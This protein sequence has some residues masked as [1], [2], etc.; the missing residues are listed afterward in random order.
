M[1]RKFSKLLALT[2]LPL[3][4]IGALLFVR[5]HLVSTILE[6]YTTRAC[7]KFLGGNCTIGSKTKDS[8]HLYFQDVHVQN[9]AGDSVFLKKVDVTWEYHATPPF[10]TFGIEMTDL[11]GDPSVMP[12]YGVWNL[13]K[14]A[15][16]RWGIRL[17]RWELHEA[18]LLLPQD[19]EIIAEGIASSD[20]GQFNAH[21][22]GYS[23]K[24]GTVNCT[25]LPDG[26]WHIELE[27]FPV[28]TLGRLLAQWT[29]VPED[30]LKIPASGNVTSSVVFNGRQIM[31]RS[32]LEQINYDSPSLKIPLAEIDFT[33]QTKEK[34]WKAAITAK[35]IEVDRQSL[36]PLK[37]S[38]TGQKYAWNLQASLGNT[39]VAIDLDG[40]LG[41]TKSLK[42]TIKAENYPL[43]NAW[44]SQK[45]LPG[46]V[47]EGTTDLFGEIDS[48]GVFVQFRPQSLSFNASKLPALVLSQGLPDSIIAKLWVDFSSGQKRGWI[49][50]LQ[51][52]LLFGG[53]PEGS[54][55]MDMEIL[56]NALSIR[57][58]RAGGPHLTLQGEV[59]G[60]ILPDK[61]TV[62]VFDGQNSRLNNIKINRLQAY[63]DQ[64]KT[65]TE[66]YFEGVADRFDLKEL[67]PFG[68]DVQLLPMMT[69]KAFVEGSYRQPGQI[70]LQG[71]WSSE[72][73]LAEGK[74]HGKLENGHRFTVDDLEATLSSPGLGTVAKY[75]LWKDPGA[76]AIDLS[77]LDLNLHTRI[78]HAGLLGKY[79]PFRYFSI[80]GPLNKLHLEAFKE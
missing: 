28:Q 58:L 8:H 60:T 78:K 73:V 25:S 1:N 5:D 36:G 27:R 10:V 24:G 76:S 29:K 30:I 2:L 3:V 77:T 17:T 22:Q 13:V 68:I 54:I 32:R 47:F 15:S 55:T 35:D 38:I 12:I 69:G 61:R 23:S 39:P 26:D 49:H 34:N 11:K 59:L 21:F 45:F 62:I 43:K 44:E 16:K 51:A 70:Q 72:L 64:D 71:N 19:E 80:K 52:K 18:V 46:I 74:I 50:T 48:K 79:A 57:N 37:A 65:L 75:G 20:K 66:L 33:L 4:F 14:G 7:A 42:G 63:L 6:K 67:E 56:Q 53:Y 40:R 31:A 9:Q 41:D